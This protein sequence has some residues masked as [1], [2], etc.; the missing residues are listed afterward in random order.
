MTTNNSR[1]E[2]SRLHALDRFRKVNEA[3][4]KTEQV[5]QHKAQ[6]KKIFGWLCTYVPEEVIHATGALPIRITGYSHESDLEDGTAYFYHN[7]CS[8]STSSRSC[9]ATAD[10]VSG[11]EAWAPTCW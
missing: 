2:E 11:A 3:F 5:L 9:C 4:P 7:N 1:A 10:A 6:G 8:F